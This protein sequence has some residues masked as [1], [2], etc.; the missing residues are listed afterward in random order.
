MCIY[1]NFIYI[2]IYIIICTYLQNTGTRCA[3]FQNLRPKLLARFVKRVTRTGLQYKF[4]YP[5]TLDP[6]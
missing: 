4:V 3:N 1:I 2:Y 5:G 6:Y